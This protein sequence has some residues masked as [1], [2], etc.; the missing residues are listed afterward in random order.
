[1]IKIT[2]IVALLLAVLA[3]W[4]SRIGSIIRPAANPAGFP[5]PGRAADR[6]PTPSARAGRA[7]LAFVSVDVR[8]SP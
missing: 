2:N 4:A 8:S 1:M 7:G 5:L 6:A 3:H